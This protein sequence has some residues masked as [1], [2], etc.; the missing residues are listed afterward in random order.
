[1]KIL[2]RLP[3]SALLVS[4]FF[5]SCNA[6][7]NHTASLSGADSVLIAEWKSK[8]IPFYKTNQDSFAAIQLQIAAKYK[9]ADQLGNWLNCYDTIIKAYRRQDSIQ[10]AIN[11]FAL[12]NQNIWR[13][14]IDSFSLITLAESNR[15]IAYIY[16]RKQSNYEKALS[17]YDEGIKLITQA[18][19]WTPDRARMFYKAAGNC[20]AR[21]DDYQK[22][23]S[24]HERNVQLCRDFKDT[25]N[26]WQGLN[27]LS[28][29]YQ[30]IGKL[31]KAEKALR[32]CYSLVINSDSTEQKVDVCSGLADLFIQKNQLDSANRYAMLCFAYLSQW[33]NKE[34]DSEAD[35]YRLQAQIF[36]LQKNFADA[37]KN[38][39]KAI[40]L[41]SSDDEL[42]RECGKLLGEFGSMY[43]SFGKEKQAMEKFHKSLQYL[44]PD[45]ISNDVY[46]VPDTSL[47]NDENGIFIAFAGMGDAC[48]QLYYKT[49]NSNYLTYAAQNYHAAT[50]AIN[51]RDKGM[52][53][54][55]SRIVFDETS[56]NILGKAKAADSLLKVESRN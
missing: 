35:A 28:I 39:S 47:L 45:F 51:K 13:E 1:M 49:K 7:S 4:G 34:A 43:V 50:L 18:N 55:S 42:R 27:D 5:S 54:E 40:E 31:D 36:S 41:M 17:F 6:P 26:L 30:N 29:P 24:Y 46:A 33:K 23:I 15:Q 37:E 25:V 16:Y 14:P 44:I 52:Q 56:K 48:M 21:M 38:Y 19:A 10:K 11:F 2:K 12:L 20:A 8:S 53:N 9:Q 22:S 32:E 3:L